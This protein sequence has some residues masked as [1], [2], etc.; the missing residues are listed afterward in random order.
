MGLHHLAA[1]LPGMEST[2]CQNFQSAGATNIRVIGS[3]EF[4]AGS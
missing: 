3:T 2:E 1:I 4:S